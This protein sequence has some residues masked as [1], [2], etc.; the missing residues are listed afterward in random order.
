MVEIPTWW[1]VLSGIFFVASLAVL[2]VTFIMVI[3]LL[4][5][6]KELK[7]KID[8][9]SDRVDAISMKVDNIADDVQS[10]V[11]RVGEKTTLVANSAEMISSLGVR[12]FEKY[13]PIISVVGLVIKAAQMAKASGLLSLPSRRKK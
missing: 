1:L 8:R 11:K 7:P 5:A 6:L 3:K 10:T 9:L 12:G 13:A 2:A 4:E